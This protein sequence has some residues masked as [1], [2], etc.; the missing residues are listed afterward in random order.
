MSEGTS[1]DYICQGCDEAIEECTCP[2]NDQ[3]EDE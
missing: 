1:A 3:E 2:D